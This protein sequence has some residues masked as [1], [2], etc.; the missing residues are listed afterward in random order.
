MSHKLTYSETKEYMISTNEHSKLEL[1]MIGLFDIIERNGITVEFNSFPLNVIGITT[2]D[3]IYMNSRYLSRM[4]IFYYAFIHEIAHWL[5]IKK[6][7]FETYVQKYLNSEIEE[8]CD[9]V[10]EEE[11]IA[12]RYACIVGEYL[13]KDSRTFMCFDQNLGD[14]INQF[15][16]KKHMRHLHTSLP[17]DY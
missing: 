15:I 12:D 2:Y 11:I 17:N 5:R 4:D 3:K 7:G 16:Y 9:F 6:M 1:N 10:I 14:E 13:N 8:F